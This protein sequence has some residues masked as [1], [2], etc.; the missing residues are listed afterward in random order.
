MPRGIYDRTTAAPRT[1]KRVTLGDSITSAQQLSDRAAE[2]AR[3]AR[4]RKDVKVSMK[5]AEY[6]TLLDW[7]EVYDDDLAEVLRACLYH[8]M[9]FYAK[10]MQGPE[11]PYSPFTRGSWR[12]ASPA[13]L[14]PTGTAFPPPP[15]P[16]P[17]RRPEEFLPRNAARITNGQTFEGPVYREERIPGLPSGATEEP[18]KAERNSA[19]FVLGNTPAGL[20][21]LPVAADYPGPMNDESIMDIAR[22]VVIEDA[23]LLDALVD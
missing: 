2:N 10:I 14:D 9:E 8:G 4:Q 20:P 19:A 7:A 1:R 21:L 6:A 12:A 16:S 23:E 3:K 11:Q 22:Q 17:Y 18:F 5:V 13:R 15:M